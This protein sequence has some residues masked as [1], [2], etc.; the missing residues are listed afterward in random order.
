MH[1]VNHIGTSITESEA[2]LMISNLF[3]SEII[4][5]QTARLLNCAVSNKCLR[6]AEPEARDSIRATLLKNMLLI[7]VGQGNE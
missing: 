1:V 3:Y 5:K 7:A 2:R 4:D 6:D